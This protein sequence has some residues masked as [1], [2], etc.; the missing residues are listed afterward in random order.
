MLILGHTLARI[1]ETDGVLTYVEPTPRL[2][3][4]GCDAC[5][6]TKTLRH[7]Q[8]NLECSAAHTGKTFATKAAIVYDTR[9][10][11]PTDWMVD[12]IRRTSSRRGTLTLRRICRG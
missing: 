10:R 8:S 7:R 5:F 1:V 11:K 9:T 6:F 3:A 12:T 2:R 4:A